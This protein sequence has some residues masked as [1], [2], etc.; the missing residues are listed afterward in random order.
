MRLLRA[1][2]M[3]YIKNDLINQIMWIYFENNCKL[4]DQKMLLIKMLYQESN[5]VPIMSVETSTTGKMQ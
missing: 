3:Q 2:H 5:P 4:S 1:Y